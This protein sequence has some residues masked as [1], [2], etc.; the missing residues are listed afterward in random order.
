M[1]KLSQ[2]T[3]L[4]ITEAS[5]ACVRTLLREVRASSLLP[6]ILNAATADAAVAGARGASAASLR[7]TC[8]SYIELALTELEPSTLAHEAGHLEATLRAALQDASAEVRG[9][10]RQAFQAFARHWPARAT[11]LKEALP[12][13]TRAH[14]LGAH[15]PSGSPPRTGSGTARAAA[16]AQPTSGDGRADRPWHKEQ[17]RRASMGKGQGGGNAFDVDVQI[18]APPKPLRYS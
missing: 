9:N 1:L 18:F 12:R 6:P 15:N 16:G 10:A 2:V 8:A 14:L 5:D 4:V 11:A 3:V 17:R 7:A 13:E